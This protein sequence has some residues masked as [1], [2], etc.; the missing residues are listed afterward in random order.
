MESSL[1]PVDSSGFLQECEG[2]REV[3]YS[4]SGILGHEFETTVLLSGLGIWAESYGIH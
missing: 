4:A 3:L 1:I 2:H